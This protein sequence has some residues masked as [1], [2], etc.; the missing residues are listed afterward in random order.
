MSS[1]P[2][3]VRT[4]AIG[5]GAGAASVPLLESEGAVETLRDETEPPRE[6][7]AGADERESE[8]S[9]PWRDNLE[10]MCMAIIMALLLKYFFVE[11]YKIPT[12]SMQPTL[13]GDERTGVFDRI[14]VDKLSY[15]F[16]DPERFEVVVFRFPLDRSKN[17]VKRLVGMPGETIRI[18]RGDLWTKDSEGAD[19]QILRRPRSVQGATWKALDRKD[20]Q[21]SKWAA[22]ASETEWEVTGRSI[23]AHGSGR[24][25][26]APN[27][28]MIVDHYTD[29]YPDGL[30][31]KIFSRR[32]NTGSNPVG[33][34]RVEGEVRVRP[35]CRS[36][37]VELSE[38]TRRYWF[39]IPGPAAAPDA[40]PS[41]AVEGQDTW[42]H[43]NPLPTRGE[44][45][46]RLP[47][48][49]T[50]RFGAQNLD[51]LLE[52]DIDGEVLC[53]LEIPQAAD[54]SALVHLRVDGGGADFDELM[55]YRD[56]YYQAGASGETYI[57]EDS[58]F[59]LGDNTQD[60]SDSREW[61]FA[62]FSLAEPGDDGQ[63]VVR[64]REIR[65][66][67]RHT[68]NPRYVTGGPNGTEVILRDE[69]GE[70]H[71]FPLRGNHKLPADPSPFVTRDL[72]QGRALAVFWPISFKH[73]V[74][75][76]GWVH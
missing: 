2:E 70:R 9:T 69:W 58:Y 35:D 76:P 65:G 12:G 49:R 4:T 61:K 20:P 66:N 13:M 52:I 25:R 75:R 7:T 41:I 28:A 42:L 59:M 22:E 33:D 31:G 18:H 73:D 24:A 40:S 60:S 19:W 27:Q 11:A 55:V 72:I 71:R 3:D 34:L 48:E 57:P 26:F 62:R 30:L 45:P 5:E 46:Y 43:E 47:A 64:R 15:K 53:A 68:E 54:Q 8:R 50:V 32:G 63:P 37:V 36:I 17:F 51:D 23:R 1:D 14:L 44:S 74:F 16:R 67:L 38:G 21:R 10:A 39:R 56:I 29:G 6:T